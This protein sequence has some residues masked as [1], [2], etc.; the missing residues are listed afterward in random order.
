MG[1]RDSYLH[2]VENREVDNVKV[3]LVDG[4]EPPENVAPT[5]EEGSPEEL[6][7]VKALY[8]SL[9]G[10]FKGVDHMVVAKAVGVYM[11]TM[12]VITDR[13]RSVIPGFMNQM[14]MAANIAVNHHERK[15]HGTQENGEA[16]NETGGGEASGTEG[17]A[18]TEGG[19]SDLEVEKG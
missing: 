15:E 8:N 10:L 13:W 6:R 7:Q 5:V 14:D 9:M 4:I 18:A 2:P 1:L 3:T 11:A 12:M 17:S 19:D 16:S